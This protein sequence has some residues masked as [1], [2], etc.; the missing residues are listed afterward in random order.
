MELA[1]EVAAQHRIEPDR[2]LVEHEQLRVAEQGD[3]E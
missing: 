2:R 1:P 3:G